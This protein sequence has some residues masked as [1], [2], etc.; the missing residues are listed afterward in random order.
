MGVPDQRDRPAF[1][2]SAHNPSRPLSIRWDRSMSTNTP[3]V[4]VSD[5]TQQS[6]ERLNKRVPAKTKRSTMQQSHLR[7]TGL[8]GESA[9][10]ES[11]AQEARVEHTVCILLRGGRVSWA[12]AQNLSASAP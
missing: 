9:V 8:A 1:G 3:T 10:D 4:D 2:R 6:T 11:D 12:A 5:V 7:A